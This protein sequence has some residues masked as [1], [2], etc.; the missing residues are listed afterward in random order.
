M[1]RPSLPWSTCPPQGEPV[2]SGWE[3]ELSQLHPL[4]SSPPPAIAPVR[5]AFACALHMHQPTIPAG[6]GGNLISH[7]QYMLMHPDEGD[8][9][10]APQFLWCYRRMGDWIP[11]LVAEGCQPRIMLDYSGNLLWGLE[12]MGQE[13][14]L[15]ALRHITV[16]DTYAPYVEWLGTCWGHAVIPSTPIADI[17]LHIRAW[18]H[19]FVALF[20]IEAL[21][22]VQ[23]FSLPEMHLPNHPDTLFTLVSC[24]KRCGYRWLLVQEHSVEQLDGSP[25]PYAAKYVPNVL[26]ARNSQGEVAEITVLIKTQGSDTKLVA[27]MQPYHEAKHLATHWQASL[28]PPCVSQIADGENGGVMMNEYARDFMPV[29]HEIKANPQAGVVGLNGSEYLALL[30]AQGVTTDHFPRCQAVHQHLLWQ[31][32]GDSAITPETVAAAIAHLE[33]TNPH[34]SMEG[35]SW[36]NHLSWVKGYETVLQPMERLSAEF[37]RLYDPLVAADPQVTQR[38]SYREALLYVL[39]SQTSCFRY[40]G[41]GRWTDYAKT[42]CDRGMA[43]L[44]ETSV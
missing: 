31:A 37:H 3:Q 19:Q 43:L 25:L 22:R 40:W 18:Q 20:G 21:Q 10:N 17:E 5:A 28:S 34:F 14:V 32:L 23:G 33:Q 26:V 27:Q 13:E 8:N 12:Q 15:D 4:P 29:W 1:P 24:L 41:S 11:Q 35:A 39:T 38:P 2:L 44:K 7:L 9:H 42:I 6:E 16:G 30:A 36:T